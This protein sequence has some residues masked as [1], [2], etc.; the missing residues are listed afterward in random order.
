MIDTEEFKTAWR[1]L[2]RRWGRE[3]DAGEAMEV[4][5]YLSEILT[6]EEFLASARHLWATREFFP[7]PAD[8]VTAAARL[9]WSRAVRA[10]GKENGV[11]P[12]RAMWDAMTVRGQEAVRILGGLD[13]LVS[14]YQR[15]PFRARDEWVAAYELHAGE[16]ASKHARLHAPASPS[17]LGRG[18][19]GAL[20]TGS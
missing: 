10:K 13:G 11:Y 3:V 5:G 6:T 2:C 12:W 19:R 1:A 20:M 14:M 17:K 4:L 9:E 8:F 18:S 16:L 15:D 7:R